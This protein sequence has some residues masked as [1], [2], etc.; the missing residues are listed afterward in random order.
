M[1]CPDFGACTDEVI[2]VFDS[3]H[4]KTGEIRAGT[5]FRI[6][7]APPVVARQDARQ[8]IVLLFLVAMTDENRTAHADPHGREARSFICGALALPDVTLDDIPASAAVLGRPPWGNPALSM[9]FLVPFECGFVVGID[10]GHTGASFAQ[11]VGH[12]LIKE[13]PDVVSKSLVL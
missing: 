7:L 8:E 1:G 5:G 13:T 2:P 9:E 4:L 11:V 10:T 12:G 6:T 3:F